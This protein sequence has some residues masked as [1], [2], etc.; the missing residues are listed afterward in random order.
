MHIVLRLLLL[1]GWIA[2]PGPTA[3]A[4]APAGP[5]PSPAGEITVF[6]AASLTNVLQDT[7][8]AWQGRTGVAVKLS[9]ASS[10]ILARQLE[11]GARADL[12]IPADLDWMDYVE[13]RGL[14]ASASRTSLLGNRLVLIAP[15][16]SAVQLAIGPGF[17]L[18]AALG[19]S[20]RLALADPASVP[21]GRYARAAL[22]TLGV[23][24]GV[25]GRLAPADNVRTA[26]LYVARG[27]APLGIV[28]LTD[29]RAEPKVRI[30][31]EFPPSSHAPIVYPAALTNVAVPAAAQF[32]AFLRQPPSVQ[33]FEAAGFA[34]LAPVA[35]ASH[36]DAA[37]KAAG[38]TLESVCGTPYWDMRSEIALFQGSADAATAATGPDARAPELAAGR[39]YA[40]QLAPQPQVRF[41]QPPG[42]QKAEQ[43]S[44]GGLA[45]F[46]VPATG[47]YRVTVGAPMWIDLVRPGA[48]LRS[49]AFA[50]RRDCP[51]YHK[52]VEFELQAKESLT[53]QLSGAMNAAAR[54]TITPASRTAA[55][56]R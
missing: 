27:E 13:Q 23:W 1:A 25:E 30:V 55:E 38:A 56:R 18:G 14:V 46:T 49:T 40:L 45:R 29:A 33:R 53:L 10:A 35:H 43:V 41:A 48:A 52:S 5:A 17:A 47:R 20:G 11:S 32:L 39:L 42:R 54:V 2:L 44:F 22:T 6:A 31:G 26:L 51:I 15:A 37:G 19:A 34:V 7:A 3:L 12:F 50:E 36:A 8:A 28:Y 9:F 16:D 21:A 24:Q 4:A